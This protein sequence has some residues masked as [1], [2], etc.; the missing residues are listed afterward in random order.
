MAD[1]V[2]LSLGGV[3]ESMARRLG[4][5][6]PMLSKAQANMSI[7]HWCNFFASAGGIT[8]GCLIGMI[9]LLWM[10][11]DAYE[12][13]QTSEPVKRKKADTDAAESATATAK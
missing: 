10:N 13:E 11:H 8:I 6:D 4:I 2:G 3:V 5:P 1:V 9:P 12:E 7:T